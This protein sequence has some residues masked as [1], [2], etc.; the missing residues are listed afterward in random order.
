MTQGIYHKGCGGRIIGR[1]TS[2]YHDDCE[3]ECWG[4]SSI[5]QGELFDSHEEEDFLEHC[6]CHTCGHRWDALTV[7]GAYLSDVHLPDWEVKGTPQGQGPTNNKEP[8]D[9]KLEKQKDHLGEAIWKLLEATELPWSD[10]CD[11]LQALQQRSPAEW[12]A[13]E[14]ERDSALEEEE[15]DESELND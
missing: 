15:D 12:K 2:V 6:Y 7:A 3:L 14:E 9:L 13:L 5:E 1:Y 10:V 4:G 11:V 8:C